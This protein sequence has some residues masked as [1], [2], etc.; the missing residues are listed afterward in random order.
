M[1]ALLTIVNMLIG[2]EVLFGRGGMTREVIQDKG[3]RMVYVQDL[4]FGIPKKRWEAAEILGDA[5]DCFAVPYLIKALN[6]EIPKVRENVAE[7]LGKLGDRGA[8]VPLV[9]S[10]KDP[11]AIVR[12][13]AGES[14]ARLH[15]RS[16]VSIIVQAIRDTTVAF[17]RRARI[18]EALA[19]LNEQ[20]AISALISVIND[21]ASPKLREEAIYALG[22][23]RAKGAVEPM[24]K[25]LKPEIEDDPKC[26]VALTQA[27]MDI[28]DKP[29]S[30]P[31]L[32]RTLKDPDVAVRKGAQDA[33]ATL[34]IN[35]RGTIP[36]LIELLEPDDTREY[37][38]MTLDSF[39]NRQEETQLLAKVVGAVGEEKKPARL[40]AI[41]RIEKVKDPRGVRCLVEALEDHDSI[42]RGRSATALG[43]IGD[44]SAVPPLIEFVDD[45]SL[46]SS[47]CII[48]ALGDIGDPRA[49][50]TLI[51]IVRDK[52]KDW[53]I[54]TV[55]AQSL[56]R[57]PFRVVLPPLFKGL[58]DADADIRYLSAVSLGETGRKEALTPLDYTADHDL[59]LK[60]REAAR[61]SAGKIRE[62]A[63][64]R[65]YG[66]EKMNR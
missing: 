2:P 20:Q 53:G 40:Y 17:A 63:P 39:L 52:S 56:G 8:V 35:D 33:L 1:L 57:L 66:A 62:K 43:V 11:Y 34:I 28:G 47:K 58:R 23:L 4:Q 16:G 18:A 9:K 12:N 10:L 13:A 64:G 19:I 5:G 37:A 7:A 24:C 55:A 44:T 41:G 49:D 25:R 42:I 21:P 14:L 22:D 59:D 46:M 48:V 60:T 27:L 61:L 15:D 50:T 65:S 54:R 32:V 29:N 26:R 51:R 30:I 31:T 6:D 45:S 36:I 38:T 3:E